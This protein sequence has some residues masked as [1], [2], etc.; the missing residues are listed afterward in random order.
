MLVLSRRLHDRCNIHVIT[1]YMRQ[2]VILYI[3]NSV[4]FMKYICYLNRACRGS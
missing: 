3:P 2:D 1:F 4:T